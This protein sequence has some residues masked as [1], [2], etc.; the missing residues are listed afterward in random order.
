MAPAILLCIFGITLCPVFGQAP[1]AEALVVATYDKITSDNLDQRLASLVTSSEY[2]AVQHAGSANAL[3]YGTPMGANYSDF[4]ENAKSNASSQSSSLT[5][6][7]ATN[8]KWTGLD[9]NSPDAYSKCLEQQVLY[10]QGLHLTVK[11]ATTS[12]I[13]LIATWR[14]QGK[15]APITIKP[16]WSGV[17]ELTAGLAPNLP[18]ELTSG[19]VPVVVKRPTQNTRSPHSRIWR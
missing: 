10:L 1:C 13:T 12:D 11:S 9:P 2:D 14:P 19:S 3:I 15:G 8:I 18:K 4:H 6:S 17:S 5:H 7:Q 16:E